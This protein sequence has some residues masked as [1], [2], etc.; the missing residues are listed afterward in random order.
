MSMKGWVT[1]ARPYLADLGTCFM[2]GRAVTYKVL[3][4]KVSHM[5][6]CVKPLRH[7]AT[8]STK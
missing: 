2:F 3:T 8:S 4:Y 1:S 5:T 6:K 7:L